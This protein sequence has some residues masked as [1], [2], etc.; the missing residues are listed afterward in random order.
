MSSTTIDD[1]LARA[2]RVLAHEPET[3]EP[4]VRFATPRS[5]RRLD[6]TLLALHGLDATLEAWVLTWLPGQ[7]TGLHDHGGIPGAFHVVRGRLWESEVDSAA[8][9]RTQTYSRGHGR[10]LPADHV[11]DVWNGGL[12]RAVSVHVYAEPL[13]AMARYELRDG[14]LDQV[15]RSEQGV[16]W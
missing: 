6:P 3:W 8:H 11:H 13:S 1:T 2:V 10:V 16:D 12:R 15:A 14:Q 9:R 5:C 4:L 7:G